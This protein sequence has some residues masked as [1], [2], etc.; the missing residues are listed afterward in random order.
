MGKIFLCFVFLISNYLLAQDQEPNRET[1]ILIFSKNDGYSWNATN[2]ERSVVKNLYAIFKSCFV[3]QQTPFQTLPAEMREQ[4]A[5]LVDIHLSNNIQKKEYLESSRNIDL[6]AQLLCSRLFYNIKIVVE[7][8]EPIMRIK[9]QSPDQSPDTED[10]DKKYPYAK[11]FCNKYTQSIDKGLNFQWQY[12][13]TWEDI[14]IDSTT[15]NLSF[16]LIFD[17]S[18]PPETHSILLTG[19]QG[20]IISQEIHLSPTNFKLPSVLLRT[21]KNKPGEILGMQLRDTKNQLYSMVAN[22]SW[23]NVRAVPQWTK[24]DFICDYFGKDSFSNIRPIVTV[25]PYQN[26]S[27][28]YFLAFRTRITYHQDMINERNSSI[29][30]FQDNIILLNYDAE[31]SG[32]NRVNLPNMVFDQKVACWVK[33]PAN[34][35]KWR[36]IIPEIKNGKYYFRE[37]FEPSGSSIF[38]VATQDKRKK[39]VYRGAEIGNKM[40]QIQ[41][42]SVSNPDEWGVPWKE[43]SYFNE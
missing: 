38:H 4:Y 39:S 36:E 35:E 12:T 33:Y 10:Y 3:N 28:N 9:L 40:E 19:A 18:K 6:Q 30:S 22:V 42:K 1:T 41:S 32:I 2:E 27:T 37:D 20:K 15:P 25:L 13:A 16:Y 11:T 21:E 34:S 26:K 17:S 7:S 24:E 8:S 29:L 23:K 5:P 14:L 43:K 31:S